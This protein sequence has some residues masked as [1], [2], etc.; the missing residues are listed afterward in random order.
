MDLFDIAIARKLAGGSGGGG[1]GGSSDF[2]TA[3]VT[4]QNTIFNKTFDVVALPFVFDEGGESA[5]A[6]V[7]IDQIGVGQSLTLT[8]PLYKGVCAWIYGIVPSIASYSYSASGSITIG[9]GIAL[10]TGDGTIT[11]S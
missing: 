4:I 6:G 8:V 5:I 2:T 9:D 1:G 11:V 3:Q 7:Y 10:I